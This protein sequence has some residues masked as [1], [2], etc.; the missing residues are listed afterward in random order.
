MKID[1][2]SIMN[3]EKVLAPYFL[4]YYETF[5]NNIYIWDDDSQDGTH[6]ILAS[7][8]KVTFLPLEKFGDRND[9]WVEEVFPQYEIYSRGKAD[10]VMIADADEFIYHPDL[11]N[12]LKRRKEGG[13]QLMLCRGWCMLSDHLPTTNGQIFEEINKG[14][15]DRWTTKY[16][17]FDPEIKVRFHKGRHKYPIETTP[18]IKYTYDRDF[19]ILHYRY[20]SED[21]IK[22]RDERNLRRLKLAGISVGKNSGRNLPDDTH[23]NPIEWYRK[24]LP[25]AEVVI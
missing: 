5:A 14:V 2:Y 21:W 7:H 22:E 8:P 3:D 23:G 15:P 24:T 10:Y 25:K 4:R 19:K 12:E 1:I 9:Y 20:L 18:D 16:S 6:E 13:I 11:I 17:I